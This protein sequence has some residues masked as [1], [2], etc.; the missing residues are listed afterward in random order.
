ML[1]WVAKY[2]LVTTCWGRKCGRLFRCS[3][4]CFPWSWFSNGWSP[5]FPLYLD[6]DSLQLYFCSSFPVSKLSASTIHEQLR[7]NPIS[8]SCNRD[9]LDKR[10]CVS[11][12][13]WGQTPF[14]NHVLLKHWTIKLWAKFYTKFIYDCKFVVNSSH[15]VEDS[16]LFPAA[17]CSAMSW[18]PPEIDHL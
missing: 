6:L 17:T 2:Y 5:S 7:T 8:S 11:H 13:S 12:K 18:N 3:A 4:Y 16:L 1:N 10:V 9:L 15:Q 14:T